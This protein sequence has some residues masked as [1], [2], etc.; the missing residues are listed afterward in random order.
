VG[1]FQASPLAF[2]L[3]IGACVL[4]GSFVSNNMSKSLAA[5]DRGPKIS[6]FSRLS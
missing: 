6:G 3:G 2:L 1:I 5:L 4:G